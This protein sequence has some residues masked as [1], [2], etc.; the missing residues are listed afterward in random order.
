M[1]SLSA[2]EASGGQL[3]EPELLMGL[4]LHTLTQQW[5]KQTMTRLSH[6][7]IPPPTH[8]H[9]GFYTL[10]WVCWVIVLF[11]LYKLYILNLGV[12]NLFLTKETFSQFSKEPLQNYYLKTTTWNIDKYYEVFNIGWWRVRHMARHMIFEKSH[13]TTALNKSNI[14]TFLHFYILR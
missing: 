5:I 6:F 12:R 3:V 2:S 14:Q 11:I 7:I 9:I 13:V 8:T 10:L 1:W 4:Q